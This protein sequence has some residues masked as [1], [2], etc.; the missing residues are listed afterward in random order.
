MH[1]RFAIG[2]YTVLLLLA[3][4]WARDGAGPASVVG[5]RKRIAAADA[6]MAASWIAGAY[7]VPDRV[8]EEMLFGGYSYAETLVAM[9]YMGEGLSLN[10]VLAQRYHR[11]GARWKEIAETLDL[12]TSKLAAPILDLLWFGRNDGHPQSIHFLPDPYPGISADLVLPAFEPTVPDPEAQQRF[13]LNGKEVANIRKVLRDPLGVS[14]AD[15]RL[16]A[17]RGLKT[18]DWV[19]AGTI[20]YFKPFPMESLLAARVGENLPWNEVTMAFGLR[21]DVL[22]QGPLSGIYPVVNGVSAPTVLVARKRG[23]YP[24][25]LPLTYDLE[26]LTPGEKRA[27]EPLLLRHFRA[28]KQEIDLLAQQDLEMGEKGLALATARMASLD[29][30]TILEDFSTYHAWTPIIKKYAIDLTGRPEYRVAVDAREGKL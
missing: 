17:G 3:P 13:R 7:Q 29:L 5:E 21:P 18:G 30:K 20:S 26:R 16:P 11:G 23:V 27:L 12:D 2:L 9:A 8:V 15:L 22:T 14:E 1:T 4:A 19:M 24:D 6:R 10:E 25:I 28:S